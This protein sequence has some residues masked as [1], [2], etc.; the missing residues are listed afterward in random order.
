MKMRGDPMTCTLFFEEILPSVIGRKMWSKRC[1]GEVPSKIA[2][3]GT[4]AFRYLLL[5]NSYE[6]WVDRASLAPG[7][8]GTKQPLYTGRGKVTKA[9]KYAGWGDGVAVFNE[10][11]KQVMEDRRKLGVAFDTMFFR[12]QQHDSGTRKKRQRIIVAND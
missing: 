7:E 6:V 5:K 9:S 11:R 2:S 10:L 1:L 4:E 3:A 12:K 8:V